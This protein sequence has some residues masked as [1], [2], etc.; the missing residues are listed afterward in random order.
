L[1]LEAGAWLAGGGR[2][3]I[4]ANAFL[5]YDRLLREQFTRVRTVAENNRYAVWEAKK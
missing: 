4:V 3:V 5:R 1:I 2:L